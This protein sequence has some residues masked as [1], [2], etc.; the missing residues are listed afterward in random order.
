MVAGVDGSRLRVSARPWRRGSY[1][2][3]RPWLGR[4]RAEVS[5]VR[6]QRPGG[7]KATEAEATEAEAMAGGVGGSPPTGEYWVAPAGGVGNRERKE[8]HQML[9]IPSPK[10]VVKCKEPLFCTEVLYKPVLP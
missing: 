1:E 4:P 2:V 8:K 5:L 10:S 9:S 3:L 7:I 6:V